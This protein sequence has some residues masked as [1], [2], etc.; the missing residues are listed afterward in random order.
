[1]RNEKKKINLKAQRAGGPP[2]NNIGTEASPKQQRPGGS[3]ETTSPG[4]FPNKSAYVWLC[5]VS[6]TGTGVLRTYPKTKKR[7][8]RNRIQ[9]L[10]PRS[11][12]PPRVEGRVSLLGSLSRKTKLWSNFQFVFV[13]IVGCS[14]LA[15]GKTIAFVVFFGSPCWP[16]SFTPYLRCTFLLGWF[17]K[18]I[19]MT[20]ESCVDDSH[21]VVIRRECFFNAKQILFLKTLEGPLGIFVFRY[22]AFS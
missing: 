13:N 12:S 21:G 11:P 4:G 15:V 22:R 3:S 7:A 18:T 16:P 20:P 14:P 10:G 6:N 17:S 2:N 1:M 19:K 8:V 5:G 9:L